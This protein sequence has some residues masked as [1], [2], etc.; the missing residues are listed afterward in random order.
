M[1]MPYDGTE[2]MKFGKMTKPG[3]GGCVPLGLQALKDFKA[4]KIGDLVLIDLPDNQNE[5]LEIARWCRENDIRVAL[6][7]FTRRGGYERWRSPSLTRDDLEEI[8]AEFGL[9]LL[10]R[11]ADSESGGILYWPKS[12]TIGRKV[13]NYENMKPCRTMPE[14][15]MAYVNYI[16]AFLDYERKNVGNCPLIGEDASFRFP[17]L[18]ECGFDS[19]CLEFLPGDPYMML[20]CIR[21]TAQAFDVSW[22]THIAMGWYGGIRVD[23]LWL[24]RWKLSILESFRNGADNIFMESGH[25]ALYPLDQKERYDFDSPEMKAA[26]ME[27]RKFMLFKKLHR[28]PEGGPE[29]PVALIHGNHDGTAGL[30]NRYAWGQYEAGPQWLESPAEKSWEAMTGWLTRRQSPYDEHYEGDESFS[31]NPPL[32]TFDILPVDAPA[33]KWNA[34]SCLIFVGYNLMTEEIYAK[35]L[36]YVKQGGRLIMFL[37][38]A[39]KDP[40]RDASPA[41]LFRD[42]KLAELTGLEVEGNLPE[43]VYGFKFI[44]ET[45][46]PGWTVPVRSPRRDPE[47]LGR[48]LPGKIRI[49]SE[50][51]RVIAGFSDYARETQEILEA[52]PALVE[53]SLGNGFV[54]T[55]CAFNYPGE[56]GMSRF[57]EHVVRMV[58]RGEQQ[59][60]RVMCTDSVRYAVFNTTSF[61]VLYLLNTEFDLPQKVQIWLNGRKS[62]AF[63]IP[64]AEMALA[65][66]AEELL[67]FPS[68][69]YVGLTRKGAEYV[70]KGNLDFTVT[71]VNLG[72]SVLSGKLNRADWTLAP[73]ENLVQQCNGIPELVE[74]DFLTEP[75]L[76]IQNVQLPY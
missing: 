54:W 65:Y 59:N 74:K 38:H 41:T 15:H 20:P 64:E 19:L 53:H 26:R 68:T 16:R 40:I 76:K 73:G 66:L 3:I 48:I 10:G 21:G 56:D 58:L 57:A 31:G 63:E 72:D 60:L 18:I 23:Q 69:R 51:T 2:N 52:R 36:K 6:S 1:N 61:R 42:G 46:V 8:F 27:L 5:A 55:V 29:A 67:I 28:R 7:E 71:L 32:G 25:Y 39:L 44:N 24:K 70:L 62:P 35:C 34:Y 22:G 45:A 13:L 12:Y 30:W 43:D 47:H 9:A 14:A 50:N 4:L 33:E 37:P 49:V 11:Y 17:N 75:D